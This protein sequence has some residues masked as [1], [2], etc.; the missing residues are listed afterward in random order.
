MLKLIDSVGEFRCFCTK[1]NHF[2]RELFKLFIIGEVQVILVSGHNL[3][4]FRIIIGYLI[5][6][7]LNQLLFRDTLLPLN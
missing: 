7:G 3:Q 5:I 2:R 1:G 6:K 4:K